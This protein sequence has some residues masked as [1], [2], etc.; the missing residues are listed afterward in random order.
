MCEEK[1]NNLVTTEL[2]G[3]RVVIVFI[4]VMMTFYT[5]V[6]IIHAIKF[7]INKVYKTKSFF[8]VVFLLMNPS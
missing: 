4:M 7:Q 3:V 2:F 6:I 5:C 8:V 1:W